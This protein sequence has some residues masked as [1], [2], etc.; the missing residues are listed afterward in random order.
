MHSMSMVKKFPYE[1]HFN[2]YSRYKMNFYNVLSMEDGEW[3][4][5]MQDW[6][7]TELQNARDNGETVHMNF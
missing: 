6:L 2:L 7:I 5:E 1:K 4:L 3:L